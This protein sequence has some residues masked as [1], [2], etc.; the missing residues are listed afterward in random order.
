MQ[1]SVPPAEGKI[2]TTPARAEVT[3]SPRTRL[4]SAVAPAIASLCCS[5]GWSG[6][7]VRASRSSKGAVIAL[8]ITTP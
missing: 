7:A 2:Q 4:N 5:V 1:K 6:E 8:S 3:T